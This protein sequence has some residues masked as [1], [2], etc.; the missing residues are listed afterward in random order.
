MGWREIIAELRTPEDFRRDWYGYATN[1]L[2]HAMIGL[3]AAF[4]IC[5]AWNGVTGEWPWRWQVAAMLVVIGVAWEVFAQPWRR[6]DSVEDIVF[7]AGWGGGGG[8]LSVKEIGSGLVLHDPGVT[9]A[10][11]VG[12][13]LHVAIGSASRLVR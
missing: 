6:W 8:L 12:C 4:A 9:T 3:A 2:S 7:F 11:F 5:A 10:M 13:F 1:Q